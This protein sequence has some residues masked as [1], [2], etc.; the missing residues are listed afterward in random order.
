MPSPEAPPVAHGEFPVVV[1]GCGQSGLLAGIR[2]RE[3]GIPFTIIDKNAGP[4]GTWWE[5]S[6]PGARVDVGSHFYCT[7]SNRPTIGPSTSP[8]TPS[9]ATTSSA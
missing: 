5:N 4:G 1:I 9:C 2:L 3:A 6:Y 7:H 8:S